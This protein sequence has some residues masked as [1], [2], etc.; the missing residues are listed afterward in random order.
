[1]PGIIDV[2]R[3]NLAAAWLML[4]VAELLAAQEGLAYQ[5]V[6]AQR[7]RAVDTMFALLIVFGVIGLV[8]DLVLRWLRNVV[9]RGPGRDVDRR[10]LHA[11]RRSGTHDRTSSSSTASPRRSARAARRSTRSTASTCT[12]TP[13]SWS[14]C[15]GASGCGKSTLLSI[16]GGLEEPTTGEVRVDGDARRSAPA[17]TG[18]W[19]SRATRCSRG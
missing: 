3:I 14:A 9:A 16:I 11:H 5:I 15:S 4:V 2:A 17:P 19:C 6:R 18:A 10:R 8:S 12:S 7:F 13:A 1:M